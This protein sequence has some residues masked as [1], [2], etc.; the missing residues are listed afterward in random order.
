MPE[1]RESWARAWRRI[2]ART[3][4]EG[5]YDALLARY[6]EPHRKYHTLRH[7][8]ECLAWF[9]SV[10][11][12]ADRPGEVEAAFWFHDA[13]YDVRRSDNEERSAEWA[14]TAAG[15]G[16]VARDVVERIHS[17]IMITKHTGAPAGADEQLVADIDLAILG[18]NKERFAGYQRQI[19][20]E[21]AHVPDGQFAQRRRAIL[22]SFL[23]RPR[24]YSTAYFHEALENAARANLRLAIDMP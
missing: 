12:L 16:G 15:E 9:E 18:S 24:I 20:A 5:T 19:R 7:L 2:G 13:I 8:G 23:D 22:Q 3:A 6:G 21:Y 10:Q 4:G 11:G 1:L 17:L 14:R